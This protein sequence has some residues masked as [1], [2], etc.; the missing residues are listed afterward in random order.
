VVNLGAG[1]DTRQ[2]RFPD[3]KWYQLD[4]PQSIEI[5]KQFFA[6][7]SAQYIAKSLL[8]FSWIE[9]VSER[10]NV[11]FI[12]EGLFMYF[13]EED[14]KAV[15]REIGKHFTHSY[16]AF[17]AIPK[18]MVGSKHASVDTSKAPMLWGLLSLQEALD[19]N[20]GWKE[21]QSFFPPD[22]F[23][24]RWKWMRVLGILPAAR[25]AFVLSLLATMDV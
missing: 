8:D 9:D 2:E 11:L 4:L 10:E 19:W 23:K 3:M 5:R 21:A 13:E 22:Y 25:K 7:G 15:F 16:L 14:V 24:K 6:P 20:L 1:L 18:T 12:A 17:N